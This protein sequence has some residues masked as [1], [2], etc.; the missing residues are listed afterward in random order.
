MN[1]ARANAMF[2]FSHGI[3]HKGK[4]G[5]SGANEESE[6]QGFP[7]DLSSFSNVDE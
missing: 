4:R 5:Q 6:D 3:K 7:I 2:Q 1:A